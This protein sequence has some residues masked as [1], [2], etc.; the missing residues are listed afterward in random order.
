MPKHLEPIPAARRRPR[1]LLL[2]GL[3]LLILITGLL[4]ASAAPV[5][6][7]TPPAPPQPLA[8]AASYAQNCAP[9]HGTTGQGDGASAAGLSVLPTALGRYEAIADKTWQA[10]F[11]VTK[12]GNMPRM[13]PPWKNR[14]SDQEIW[15]TVAYAWSLHTSSDEVEQGKTLY[16]AN[17]AS[18]HGPDGKGIVPGAPDLTDF[19]VTSAVSQA[20]WAATLNNGKG[21]M[22]AFAGKL[23]DAAQRAALVYVRSLSLGGPLFRRPLAVSTGVISG[24]VTNRTTGQPMPD[25]LVE[26]GIFDTAALL[27]QR[28]AT[29]DAAGIYRFTD[30]P[31]DAGL[32]FAAR[33]QYPSGVP[34]STDFAS[35][36]A[37]QTA[38]DLPISVYETTGDADGV[39]IER[40]HFIV[41]FS[42]GQALVAELL[43][44]SLDGDRAYAGDGNA[45][46]RFTLPAGAADLAINNEEL[47]GRFQVTADGFV[48]LLA[49]PPG[50]N[51][52][53]VLYRY[54]LPYRGSTLELTRALSYPAANVN[55]LVSDV[56]QQ[57]IGQ[58]L[59]DQGLR[60]TQGGNY[61][62]FIAQDV[63]AGQALTLR[64]TNL[65]TAGAIGA[66]GTVIP[67]AA[68]RILIGVLVA[69]AVGAAAFL[70]ALPILRRRAA[71]DVGAGLTGRAALIDALAELDL[72]HEAGELSDAA[73]RDQ[74]LRLK[75]QLRDLLQKE[76]AA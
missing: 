43:V 65:P 52:R 28:T 46:L 3:T 51:V 27:E 66:S 2:S 54:A 50:Q 1:G 63:P 72:A 19:A 6:Q 34:Y 12:N 32:A 24:T 62:N 26:L 61:Y 9:C 68:S 57:I 17:C 45:V 42:A 69:L 20:T 4:T 47:G 60:Q 16:A 8:G 67:S 58:G 33:V 56:G 29:T 15:D 64:M 49:L 30:L 10:L 22:P 21:A 14:L 7:D 39:Y 5:N 71:Q 41:E 40:V 76:G 37:G 11:D 73:Y 23:D 75:A 25:L 48:D 18:C 74:R 55:A 53:Q 35:F 13:M 36:E 70:V 38:I 31:T 59:T 44:F